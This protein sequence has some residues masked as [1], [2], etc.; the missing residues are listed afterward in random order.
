MFNTLYEFLYNV[1]TGWFNVIAGWLLFSLIPLGVLYVKQAPS[2]ESKFRRMMWMPYVIVV[3]LMWVTGTARDHMFVENTD[4]TIGQYVYQSPDASDDE[5][6]VTYPVDEF[7]TYDSLR[8][9]KAPDGTI[10]PYS[11][12]KKISQNHTRADTG[13]IFYWGFHVIATIGILI[14]LCSEQFKA[15]LR[16]FAGSFVA[17]GIGRAI[18][19]RIGDSLKLAGG[20]GMAI[21]FLAFFALVLISFVAIPAY[22]AYVF[23]ATYVNDF[24]QWVSKKRG[25]TG[26]VPPVLDAEKKIAPLDISA[27][28][29]CGLHGRSRHRSIL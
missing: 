23:C 28:Q 6:K 7:P 5:G 11:V 16:I 26:P 22:G 2:G 13:N 21:I 10:A 27:P 20:M 4:Y 8:V 24:G 25:Y 1:E 18:G 29:A 3:G 17:H 12:A 19:G 14:A 15:A 9:W